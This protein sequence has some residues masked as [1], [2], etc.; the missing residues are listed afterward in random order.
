MKYVFQSS[1]NRSR[2][3]KPR[4][5]PYLL[6]HSQKNVCS[7]LIHQAIVQAEIGQYVNFHLLDKDEAREDENLGR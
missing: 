4:Y 2:N 1:S 6:H 7:Y 5:S 3:F